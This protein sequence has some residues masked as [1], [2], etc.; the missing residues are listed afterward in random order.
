MTVSNDGEDCNQYMND[1][2][3]DCDNLEKYV[4]SNLWARLTT[5]MTMIMTIMMVSIMIAMI[6]AD[7]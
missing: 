5:T 6:N 1:F 2:D 3:E 7:A 4:N